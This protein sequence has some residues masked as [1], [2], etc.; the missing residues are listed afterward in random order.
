[1]NTL[2][3][4]EG[5]L[6]KPAE[7]KYTSSGKPLATFEVSV[8]NGYGKTA[9]E[10]SLFKVTAWEQVAADVAEL[11]PETRLTV[12]GRLTQR[13]YDWNGQTKTATEIVA[14]QV[15]ARQVKSAPQAQAPVDDEPLPF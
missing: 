9:K 14:N 8:P 4:I 13:K 12:Y 7:L 5:T 3:V 6:H 10:P 15:G 1:M 11:P 2:V